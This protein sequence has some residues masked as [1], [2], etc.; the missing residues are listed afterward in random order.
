MK[1]LIERPNESTTVYMD[2]AKKMHQRPPRLFNRNDSIL[3]ISTGLSKRQ[4]SERKSWK[5]IP[6][7]LHYQMAWALSACRDW[8]IWN[9]GNADRGMRR[10]AAKVEYILDDVIQLESKGN[11]RP[12]CLY[13]RST[14]QRPCRP[15]LSL[16]MV[17]AVLYSFPT[18]KF[19]DPRYAK[20]AQFIEYSIV[21]YGKSLHKHMGS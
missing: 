3:T 2:Q 1:L 21:K 16:I 13:Y 9:K 18:L 8:S 19:F 15:I 20:L 6:I 14:S 17:L 11:D 7:S 10:A 12:W 5:P 4:W